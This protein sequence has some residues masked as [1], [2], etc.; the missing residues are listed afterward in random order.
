MD[1]R[2]YN[3]CMVVITHC[4]NEDLHHAAAEHPPSPDMC[5][6]VCLVSLYHLTKKLHT[7]SQPSPKQ[8]PMNELINFTSMLV[9]RFQNKKTEVGTD[10]VTCTINL[11][12]FGFCRAI[13]LLTNVS[14]VSFV[15]SFTYS[16]TKL[17]N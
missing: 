10:N 2:I 13:L 14:V 1:T 6:C 17:I 9:L 8:Q 7:P 4:A 16:Q 5:V 11:A 3:P 15:D 12:V